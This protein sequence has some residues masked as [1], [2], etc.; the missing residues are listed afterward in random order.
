MRRLNGLKNFLWALGILLCLGVLLISLLYAA[1]TPYRGEKERGGV[2]LGGT[3]AEPV[4][5]AEKAG[6]AQ[7]EQGQALPEGSLMRLGD[8]A[9]GGQAYLDSLTFLVDSSLTG[10]RSY[11][12]LA[13]GLGTTQVWAGPEGSIGAD[14]LA[15]CVIRYPQDGSVIGAAT[16]AMVA[17]PERL[18]ICLGGDGLGQVDEDGFKAGYRAL[19]QEL[20]SNSP[21]TTLILCPLPSVTADYGGSG[22]LSV[23]RLAEANRWIRELCSESGA[24]YAD[25]SALLLDADGCLKS[26]YA[27]S[28]GRSLNATGLSLLLGY[29]RSHTA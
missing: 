12:L 1:F 26:E 15:S 27:E 7:S 14:S 10:L 25:Y 17:R 24:W 22:G 20:K 13:D 9:D 2:Q 29:L 23:E 4:K 11:G 3:A 8:S 21:Y 18:V 16:A 5:S 28:N 6:S 19:L